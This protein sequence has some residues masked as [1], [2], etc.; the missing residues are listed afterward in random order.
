MLET[1]ERII[2]AAVETFQKYGTHRTTMADVAKQAGLSR[3]TLYAT[4]ASKVELIDKTLQYVSRR[5][6]DH[7][8]KRL[9]N[10]KNLE[11]QL[12]VYFDETIIRPFEWIQS[13]PEASDLWKTPPPLKRKTINTTMHEHVEFVARLFVPYAAF[14]GRTNQTPA[15]L[16]YFVVT[17]G[18]H[19]KFI[20]ENREALDDLVKSLKISVLTLTGQIASQHPKS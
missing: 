11:E 16:A 5:C 18:P 19:I 15:Q 10:C 3:Q 2:Q 7:A 12:D 1:E 4:F 9:I 17:I 20:A 14:I 13:S 6:L 8:E